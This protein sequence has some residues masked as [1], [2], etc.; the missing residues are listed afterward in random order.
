VLWLRDEEPANFDRVASVL[1]PK[2]YIRLRLTGER[3]TD[4]S[5]AAG[6]LFLDLRSRTWSAEVLT[7]LDVPADWLPPVMEGP[8]P[9]GNVLA[10][11]AGELGLPRGI[12]VAAGGGDNAAAAIGTAI[13]R[14]GLLSSSIGTSGVLFAH[15]DDA[16]IDPSD[17]STPSRTPCPMR[18]AC[19]P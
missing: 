14:G 7:A 3:A 18:I 17:G 9:S 15:V 2:D 10:D 6:T 16:V 13:T 19:L 4:A 11:V 8:E 5:D 12:P 1:L